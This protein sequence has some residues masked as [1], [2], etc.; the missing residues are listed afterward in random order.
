MAAGRFSRDTRATAQGYLSNQPE[1][2]S[3]KCVGYELLLVL[4]P[5]YKWK[6]WYLL[7]TNST[8]SSG[9]PGLSKEN[10]LKEAG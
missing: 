2:F 9:I 1:N 4:L 8:N 7:C 3:C 5:I 10:F 6:Q